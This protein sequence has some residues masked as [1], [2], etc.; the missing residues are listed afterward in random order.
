M[1]LDEDVREIRADIKVL[2]AQSASMQT[3][4]AALRADVQVCLPPCPALKEHLAE[5]KGAFRWVW[6]TMLAPVL[7]AVGAYIAALWGARP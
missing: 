2:I 5:T 3:E 6:Q 7:A 1:S 4:T